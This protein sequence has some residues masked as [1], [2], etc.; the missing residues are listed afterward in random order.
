MNLRDLTDETIRMVNL[1]KITA[2]TI[3]QATQR[4]GTRLSND[5]VEILHRG[6]RLPAYLVAGRWEAVVDAYSY[7]ALDYQQ[8]ETHDGV[9]AR[10]GVWAN[11]KP[12]LFAHWK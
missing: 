9:R 10:L 6:R 11:S 5:M 3:A 12:E 8:G 4:P 1:P 2:D 7:D